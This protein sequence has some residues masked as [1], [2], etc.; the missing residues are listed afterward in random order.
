MMSPDMCEMDFEDAESRTLSAM[1]QAM[2]AYEHEQKLA[3][4]TDRAWDKTHAA[5]GYSVSNMNN[6]LAYTAMFSTLRFPKPAASVL[7]AF[8]T[9]IIEDLNKVDIYINVELAEYISRSCLK[10]KNVKLALP[11]IAL[12]ILYVE[13]AIGIDQT[14]QGPEHHAWLQMNQYNTLIVNQTQT[15]FVLRELLNSVQIPKHDPICEKAHFTFL[16]GVRRLSS[17]HGNVGIPTLYEQLFVLGNP[18][19]VKIDDVLDTDT[20]QAIWLDSNDYVLSIATI[21][22]RYNSIEFKFTIKDYENNFRRYRME[23]LDIANVHFSALIDCGAYQHIYE[24]MHRLPG[25]T[26]KAVNAQNF[27]VNRKTH[28]YLTPVIPVAHHINPTHNTVVRIQPDRGFS[29]SVDFKSDYEPKRDK[30]RYDF[31]PGHNV[32]KP[33]LAKGKRRFK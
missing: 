10:P 18:G 17:Y 21:A 22:H 32:D 12:N 33:W 2:H 3:A 29:Y 9:Q 5:Y 6:L 11:V 26:Q 30:T 28:T 16:E 1:S 19:H 27:V 7:R 4:E 20:L 13:H 31:V 14:L 25:S 8:V 15:K 24:R 23:E